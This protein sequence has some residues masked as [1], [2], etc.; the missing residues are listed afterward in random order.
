M[1]SGNKKAT[2]TY[3]NLQVKTAGLYK[4]VRPFCYHQVLK[5]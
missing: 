4:Y 3:T 2:Y 1:P 5:G